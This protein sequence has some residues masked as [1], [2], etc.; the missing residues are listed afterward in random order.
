LAK[1]TKISSYLSLPTRPP[2]GRDGLVLL[3]TNTQ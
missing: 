1:G 2:V 3:N